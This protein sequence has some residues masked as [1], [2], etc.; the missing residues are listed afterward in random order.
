VRPEGLGKL[1]KKYDDIIGSRTRDLPST[2]ATN[3]IARR[4]SQVLLISWE[5]SSLIS[6]LFH[7]PVLSDTRN[8]NVDTPR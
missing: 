5:F 3:F 6:T 1:K 8:V 7:I 4:S 2:F